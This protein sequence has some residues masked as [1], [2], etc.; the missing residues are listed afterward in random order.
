[1]L[2]P[3]KDAEARSPE[4]NRP[5]QRQNRGKAQAVRGLK[6]EQA[7]QVRRTLP[8]HAYRKELAVAARPA[9]LGDPDWTPRDGRSPDSLPRGGAW[10]QPVG[11]R[12]IALQ[13]QHVAGGESAGRRGGVSVELAV[14]AWG[15]GDFRTFGA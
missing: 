10:I 15:G 6:K 4:Q 5:V 1:M 7:V 13:R 14:G 3:K 2:L 12:G 8:S 9:G 11:F